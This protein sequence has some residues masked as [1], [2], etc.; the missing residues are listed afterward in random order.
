M[1]TL[2]PVD[3]PMSSPLHRLVSLVLSELRELD[4]NVE[5]ETDKRGKHALLVATTTTFNA[6]LRWS[7]EGRRIQFGKD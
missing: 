3:A 6:S 1:T 2:E 5:H 4:F 7:G